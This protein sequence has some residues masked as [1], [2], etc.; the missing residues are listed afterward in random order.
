MK[1][2][3]GTIKELIIQIIVYIVAAMII[4]PLL[5]F[6]ID[7][8]IRKREFI[9]SINNH[10]IEPIIFGIIYGFIMWIIGKKKIEK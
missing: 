7:I 2:E 10:I 4:W 9:Y 5:D 3:K 1:I 6:I 8:L